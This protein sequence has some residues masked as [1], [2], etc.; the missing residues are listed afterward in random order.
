MVKCKFNIIWG[1][2]EGSGVAVKYVKGID[3]EYDKSIEAYIVT[4]S[5]TMED[6]DGGPVVMIVDSLV[7]VQTIMNSFMNSNILDVS[8]IQATID[9]AEN[10]SE[11]DP[12]IMYL[13]RKIVDERSRGLRPN[14][15]Y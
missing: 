6:E 14:T 7:K 5:T 4:F 2:G 11:I 3:S 13:K 8:D 1:E 9:G 15:I 12:D 10:D